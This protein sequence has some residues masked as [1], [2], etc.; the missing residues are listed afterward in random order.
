M[1]DR[2]VSVAILIAVIGSAAFQIVLLVVAGWSG[3]EVVGAASLN[4]SVAVL[5]CAIALS[6]LKS[7]SIRALVEG[8]SLED[9]CRLRNTLLAVVGGI[10]LVAYLLPSARMLA[11]LLLI[12]AS[13]QAA[14][15]NVSVWQN[16]KR[17][18]LIICFALLRYGA[19]ALILAISSAL[20]GSF[21]VGLT[22]SALCSVVLLAAEHALASKTSPHVG[23]SARILS[24][25][26]KSGGLSGAYA[27][28]SLAAGLNFLPQTILR[29]LIALFGGV[30]LLGSFSIQY[31][32]AMLC[33]PLITAMSQQ[34]LAR[35]ETEWRLILA[36]LAKIGA[37]SCLSLFVVGIV[38]LSPARFLLQLVF[39]SWV[40]LPTFPSVMIL[41]SSTFLSLT[42]YLGFMSVA[43]ER[44]FAQSMANICYLVLLLSCSATL[45][46]VY[47]IDGVLIGFTVATLARL[48]LLLNIV[49]RAGLQGR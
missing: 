8:R 12:K 7:L 26:L 28:L 17:A 22:L 21:L 47:G 24:E 44:P 30:K 5:V 9:L 18:D 42:V 31:Q 3:I 11:P 46:A 48:T 34:A 38:F 40:P 33:I 35:R 32:I 29:Y 43:L 37:V 49:R 13:A 36:D 2:F 6:D 25:L 45:G 4:Q 16:K 41:I 15:I 10:S 19:V 1:K 14:D 39:Q 23:M 27:S 20:S